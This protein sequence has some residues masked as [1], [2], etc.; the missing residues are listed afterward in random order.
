M[1]FKLVCLTLAFCLS[2]VI[3]ADAQ[4][5]PALKACDAEAVPLNLAPLSNKARKEIVA[6]VSRTL[7][8]SAPDR[9]AAQTLALDSWASYPKLSLTDTTI[10]VTAGP[11]NP[12][13]GVSNRQIWVF[14]IVRRHAELILEDWN[15]MCDFDPGS[16]HNGMVDLRLRYRNSGS[17]DT[18]TTFRFDGKHYLPAN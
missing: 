14:R 3:H 6:A 13:N 8:D 5:R 12:N 17:R 4:P 15:L 18:V 1:N 16:Y 7:L 2:G 9:R 10:V 11:D